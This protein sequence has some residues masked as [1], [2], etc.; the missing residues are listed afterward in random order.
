MKRPI[1]LL[2]FPLCLLI[3]LGACTKQDHLRP[4]NNSSCLL[5]QKV[6]KFAYEVTD[7]IEVGTTILDRTVEEIIEVNGKKYYLL[8]GWS[9]ITDYKTDYLYDSEGRII[10]TSTTDYFP[11]AT[12]NKDLYKHLYSY[13]SGVINEEYHAGDFITKGIVQLNAQG[14]VKEGTIHELREGYDGEV[15]IAYNADG[16]LSEIGF[17]YLDGYSAFNDGV[18]KYSIET[19]NVVKAESFRPKTKNNTVDLYEYDLS[20][21]AIPNPFPFFGKQSQNLITKF[22]RL[23]SSGDVES[24]YEYRYIF[25]GNEKIRRITIPVKTAIS[26]PLVVTDYELNCN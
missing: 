13:D 22:T 8:S 12:I 10:Q 9:G 1:Q 3:I 7:K 23:N 25:D 5:V 18:R 14:L 17:T 21:P 19:G 26:E 24:S 20:K 4:A 6:Q 16:Y 11:G 2:L 15:L